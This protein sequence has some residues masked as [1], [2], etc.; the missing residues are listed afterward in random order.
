MFW[1]NKK[2]ERLKMIQ[3]IRPTSKSSLLLQCLWAC[4]GDVE[5]AKKLYEYFAE[6]LPDLPS[7]DPV[8]PTWQQSTRDTVN[9]LMGWLK[10]N[11]DTLAQ[12]MEFIRGMFVKQT[13]P[14]VDTPTQLP[15]IN[16]DV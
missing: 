8:P 2:K 12:G 7:Q 9:G 15:P 4:K 16:S 1:Q 13:P 6:G 5:E 10:E 14:P 3:A 11:Q